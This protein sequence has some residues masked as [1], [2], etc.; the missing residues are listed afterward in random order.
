MMTPPNNKVGNIIRPLR[1]ARTD[2]APIR[3]A[4]KEI[5]EEITIMAPPIVNSV[6]LVVSAPERFSASKHMRIGNLM[7]NAGIVIR[8]KY[9]VRLET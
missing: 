9:F 6:K 7:I 1:S 4:I 2:D 8:A 3:Y 5:A